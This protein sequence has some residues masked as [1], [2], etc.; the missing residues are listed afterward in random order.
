MGRITALIESGKL[1]AD[2]GFE[3]FDPKIDRVMICGS[4]GML[5][6]VKALVAAANFEEGANSNP[7]DFVVERAF[8]D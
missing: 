6:D 2:L 1:F 7:A 5:S 4:L 8:V 3:P